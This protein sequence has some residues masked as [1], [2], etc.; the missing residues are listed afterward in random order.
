MWKAITLLAGL[1]IVLSP[2]VTALAKAERARDS[3]QTLTGVAQDSLGR[4]IA[5]VKV[6]LQTANGKVVV[7]TRTDSQG[8]F[9][10]ERLAPGVYALMAVKAEFRPAVKIVSLTGKPAS[11]T[12]ALQARQALSL[13][14]VAKR[15]NRA[16]NE[17]SP[18]SGASVYHFSRPALSDLPQGDNTPLNQ[19]LLQ[20]PGVAQDSYGQ[21]HVRGEHGDL[22]YRLN[23]IQLPQGI[24][25]EF[26]QVYSPR[27]AQTINLITGA[28]PA[29]YGYQ[30]AGVVDIRTRT[31]LS[32]S[33]GDLD[34]YGGQHTTLQPSFQLGGSRGKLDYYFTGQYLQSQLGVQ[35]PTPGPSAYHDQTWQG[36]GFS[37]LSYFLSPTQRLSLLAGTAVNSFQIPNNPN[38]PQVFQL[39]GVPFYPSV[40]LTDNQL[41]QNYYGVLAWQG[42]IGKLDYQLAAFSRYS[43]LSF[44]P[45]VEGD[46]IYNGA[47]QQ[48]DQRF[49]GRRQLSSHGRQ[50]AAQR[51]LLQRRT[52]GNRQ[53][54]S[55]L[56]LL[57]R[58]GRS[59]QRHSPSSDRGQPRHHRLAL[60]NLCRGRMASG[61]TADAELRRPFR[62]L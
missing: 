1:S 40:N 50:Y 46:L 62:S 41:E 16:R 52:R 9:S 8:R 12:L 53:S 58:G 60:R 26:G 35:P 49:A 24:S 39:A 18:Q 48:L 55:G 29:Q 57:R 11:V 43:T 25:S 42:T 28:L 27:L 6:E 45:D 20:A 2:A 30:T 61:R 13:T 37:Y 14:V 22:Q 4:P 36:Q 33:G 32:L 17:F 59:A 56:P 5:G 7:S 19:V 31:G 47:A 15:L 54:R 44:Y 38:Q 3:M 21:V 51:L 10:F 34:M 23:G